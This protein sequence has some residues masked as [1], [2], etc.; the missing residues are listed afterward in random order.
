MKP[1]LPARIA[2]FATVIALFLG[3][4]AVEPIERAAFTLT[5]GPAKLDSTV[6]WRR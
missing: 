5:L 3:A 1:K 4:G 6:H 2:L